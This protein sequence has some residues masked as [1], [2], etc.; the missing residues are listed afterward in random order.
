MIDASNATTPTVV[1]L[2]PKIFDSIAYKTISRLLSVVLM[3][4]I[5]M[6]LLNGTSEM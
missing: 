4:I 5:K 6:A 2:L 3:L 1:F